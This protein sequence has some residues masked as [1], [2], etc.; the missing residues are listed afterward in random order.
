[1]LPALFHPPMHP[2][3]SGTPA[4]YAFHFDE[5][6][7]VLNKENKTSDGKWKKKNF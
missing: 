1:M 2:T 5:G 7:K 4:H 3:D 6:N